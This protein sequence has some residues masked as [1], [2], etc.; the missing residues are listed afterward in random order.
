MACFFVLVF[1]MVPNI[2]KGVNGVSVRFMFLFHSARSTLPK[3]STET[4]QLAKI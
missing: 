2:V 4:N 1:R 3:Q